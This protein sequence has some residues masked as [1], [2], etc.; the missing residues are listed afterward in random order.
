MLGARSNGNCWATSRRVCTAGL[1]VTGNSDPFAE[2]QAQAA[3]GCEAGLVVYN[4]AA[5]RIGAALVLAPEVPLG[6]AMAMFPLCAV[7]FQAALGSLAPEKVP[8]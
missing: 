6:Q 8:A 1:A 2:A 3:A 7:A 5:D 4:L